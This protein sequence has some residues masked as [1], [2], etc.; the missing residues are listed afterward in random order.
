MARS[1]IHSLASRLSATICRKSAQ[2]CVSVL[3]ALRDGS[4]VNRCAA[5]VTPGH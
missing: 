1:M 2:V 5:E 4:W 3:M